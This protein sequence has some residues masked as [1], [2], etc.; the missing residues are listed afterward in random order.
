VEKEP[1]SFII[2]RSWTGSYTI[3]ISDELSV[4]TSNFL[5]FN[6]ILPFLAPMV[7]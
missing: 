7:T 4:G 3:V 1:K 6:V 5:T 2:E